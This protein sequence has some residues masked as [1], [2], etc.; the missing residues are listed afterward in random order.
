MPL[1]TATYISQLV[2]GDPADTDSEGLSG[3]HL[4]LIKST[5]LATFPSFTAA[6]IT[7]TTAQ[8]NALA[9]GLPVFALGSAASPSVTFG[10]DATSG[11]WSAGAGKVDV[12]AGGVE[13]AEFSSAGLNITSGTLE[14]AGA[15]VLPLQ[16]ANIGANQVVTAAI[17]A[18]NV[19]YAKLQNESASTLL[20][21][22]TGSA[23]APSEVTIGTGLAFSGS[24]L[25]NTGPSLIGSFVNNLKITN[26]STVVTITAD[27][28]GLINGSGASVYASGINVSINTAS[29]GAGGM[30]VTTGTRA[31]SA[32]YFWW[33]I[34]N[35]TT[36]NAL[37]STQVT[38]AGLISSGD[39]PGGYT[40]A[41]LI[42]A[43]FTDASS[44]LYAQFQLQREVQYLVGGLTNTALLP[45]LVSGG[46]QGT[47]STTTPTLAAI[48]VAGFVPPNA[49][50]IKIVASNK[51]KGATACD[52]LAAPNV[53]YGGTNNGPAGTNGVIYPV[54]MESTLPD[55][56]EAEMVLE[57]TT[58]AVAYDQA[59]GAVAVLGFTLPI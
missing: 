56:Q 3:A 33:L 7:I 27:E 59:G 21:N 29:T 14:I 35:G 11:L 53:S 38:L 9:A 26:T 32:K 31:V 15:A 40:Y 50:T 34:S 52:L 46:T 42:G 58:I 12:S 6:P 41:K 43:N 1:E 24:T 55:N 36:T 49:T 23:A 22:P 37:G 28:A 13:I 45:L 2:S 47:Y 5:L 8:L 39:L 18:S 25:K 17:A 51:C 10:A 16:S 57:G 48:S 54:W 30:G 44:N 4:R 19:T 20:G